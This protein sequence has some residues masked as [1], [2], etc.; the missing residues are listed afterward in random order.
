MKPR[1]DGMKSFFKK[2]DNTTFQLATVCHIT[3]I[4]YADLL[5]RA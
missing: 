3:P 5:R 4:L 1:F 2:E